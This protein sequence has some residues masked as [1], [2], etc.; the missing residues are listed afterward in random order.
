MLLPHVPRLTQMCLSIGPTPPEAAAKAFAA[1]LQ[2]IMD[3]MA[4]T[5]PQQ[6]REQVAA[7]RSE[8]AEK[9]LTCRHLVSNA[10]QRSHKAVWLSAHMRRSSQI[11]SA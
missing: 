2:G 7:L 11:R 9:V 4:P 8:L 3:A 10:V 5:Q 6:L 1:S